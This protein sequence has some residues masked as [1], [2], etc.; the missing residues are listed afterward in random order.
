[1]KSYN[2]A[3]PIQF[4]NKNGVRLDRIFCCEVMPRSDMIN[5][6]FRIAYK[7]EYIP[8]LKEK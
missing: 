2:N 6:T 8:S 1:L 4:C 3:T 7:Q 5:K